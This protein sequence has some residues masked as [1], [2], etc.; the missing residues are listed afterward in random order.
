MKCK[1]CLIEI[2][3][4]KHSC[5]RGYQKDNILNVGRKMSKETRNKIS[6]K[7]RISHNKT[8]WKSTIGIATAKK[9]SKANKNNK[10][11]SESVRRYFKEVGMSEEAR[12][13]IRK[14][15][16]GKRYTI[17]K[18]PNHGMRGKH[19]TEKHKKYIRKVMKK[20]WKNE[21]W[22]NVMIKKCFAGLRIRPNNKEIMMIKI[23]KLYNL[24]FEYV[25]NSKFYIGLYNPDFIN[26]NKKL[27]I[28]LF[29]DYWHSKK[30]WINRDKKKIKLYKESGYKV[31]IIW[32][33]ELENP[34]KI[35]EKV[36]NFIDI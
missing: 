28:E 11:L 6:E 9:I 15:H 36:I 2:Y 5:K 7:N 3:G 16:T 20:L 4:D 12:N 24:N 25:G 29:G 27:I 26:K 18:Y 22:A 31:L 17:E 23:F 33:K 35:V 8:I 21:E 32:E 1:Y 14:W 30:D 34:N 10:K 19:H 13:K